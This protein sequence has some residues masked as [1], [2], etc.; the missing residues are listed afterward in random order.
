MENRAFGKDHAAVSVLGLGCMRFPLQGESTK[1]IDEKQVQEMMRAAVEGGV[2][3]ID[4]AWP[5][6]GGE[7][8]PVVGRAIQALGIRDQIH[9]ATKL[10]SWLIHSRQDMDNYLDQQLER[11]QTDHI[12]YYLVH[13]LTKKLWAQVQK[14]GIFDFLDAA[15]ASGKVR[16]VGFSFHDS[17]DLF[18]EIIEAYPWEFCQIQLNYL[19]ETYQAG[20]KGLEFA[21]SHGLSVIVME[22]LRGG[23]LVN[24]L[25][26]E[27]TALF[28]TSKEK[29]TAAAWGLRY[30]WNRPEVSLVLSGMSNLDQIMENVETAKLGQIGN[31]SDADIAILKEVQGIL[32]EKIQVDCTGC[33]Y[34]VPCPHGVDIPGCFEYY[35]NASLFSDEEGAK[36]N[37]LK[38]VGSSQAASN[39]VEC[40]LCES[41]CPQ[42]IEI[43]KELKKV[44]A[45]FG[46]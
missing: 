43:R 34:C 9:L 36:K 2:N 23:R 4:T 41:H 6:H 46:E 27:A 7:S 10:P 24:S 13:T 26:P 32:H 16:H 29:K 42:G 11:L 8:E 18:Q 3:Y 39:C 17:F 30:L 5:Y 20:M 35:N 33:K 21:A 22:P 14:H 15:L 38:F 31:L 12:D 1:E 40:G 19:D 45:T 37:Y 28:E 25:P 44:L